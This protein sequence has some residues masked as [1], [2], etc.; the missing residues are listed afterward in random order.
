M[1]D[2][3]P[4]HWEF[5]PPP[6]RRELF[7]VEG[8]RRL[9][10]R[11]PISGSKNAALKLLA[12]AVLT[13]ERCRFTNVPEIEDVR[14]MAETLRDLGVVVDHPEPNVYEVAS[15][16]VDWLFVPLEAAAKMR[17]SFI[18]LG[19]LLSRFG[20]VII[21]NPGGDRIGRRPVDLHVDAMRALG[22]EIEYRNGYYFARAPGRLRG[23]GIGFPQVTVMG[24]ENA[25]LAA[26]LADGDTV[27]RPAAQE[28]EVDDLIAFLQKMG[29]DVERT[30]PDKIVVSGKRRLRGAQHRIISDRIE[31]G[32]FVVAAAVTGGEVTLEGAPCEHLGA[33]LEAVARVGVDVTCGRDR[34]EV[35]SSPEAVAGYRATDITTGPYPEFATDLQPPTCVLLS[36]ATGDSQV[37]ETLFEDRLEW[38]SGLARM[39]ARIT[40]H[41]DQHATISGPAQLRGTDVEIGD[42]RAGAS[43]ILAALA[44]EGVSTIHGAH[45]VHRGYENIERKFLDL[46]A[47]IERRAEEATGIPA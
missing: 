35:R 42:L 2:A 39:G 34:I 30:A 15:G 41:D 46:G 9:V 33:F 31:A 26:T 14:V 8:G 25:M 19:P 23:S 45:H 18:L 3:R 4:F 13:G 1:A 12:A 22:A 44:A 20:R 27:I 5:T 40:E 43:L 36:Q 28:P 32:T 21:S 6:V 11:V 24:T 47:H 16:D 17:A 37:H 38:L 10:G 29:A 7:R